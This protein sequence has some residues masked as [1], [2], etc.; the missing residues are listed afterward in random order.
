MGASSSTTRRRSISGISLP[1]T[2]PRQP[3]SP[4]WC[5]SRIA[6][7]GGAVQDAH[8]SHI[9]LLV[10]AKW[11]QVHPDAR[12]VDLR[13][14]ARGPPSRQKY[15]EG[16]IPG[17]IFVDLDRDLSGS[18]GPGRHPFP[19]E[20]PL[21]RVLARLGI[22]ADTH[23]VVYDEGSSSTAARLWFMLRAFGHEKVSLL[24]GG[25]RAWSEAGLPPTGG[26]PR[27]A[28]APPPELTVDPPPPA[29]LAHRRA[30]RSP[31]PGAP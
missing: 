25:L 5:H 3:T 7:D 22:G 29:G 12:I 18:G 17:A 28:A 27:I 26:E 31:V 23:V 1:L 4:R 9:P 10:D 2:S 20:E 19:S 15:E 21:A 24:D 6:C 16:H 8:M 13:W 30:R 14:T 11:V